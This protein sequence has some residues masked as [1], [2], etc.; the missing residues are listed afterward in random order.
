M[1][2]P[3][4][5]STVRVVTLTAALF[6]ALA[7]GCTPS[8]SPSSDG[9]N[10]SADC[11]SV[12]DC[13]DGAC[14][15]RTTG[16]GS[17][18]VATGSSRA[19]GAS[20]SGNS[21]SGTL[22]SSGGSQGSSVAG[23]SS[24][25]GP[26]SSSAASTS[27]GGSGSSAGGCL[28]CGGRCVDAETDV[29]F[30]GARGD[31]LG[32]NAGESCLGGKTCFG[33]LCVTPC[34]NGLLACRNPGS[35][36]Q[37]CVD[38]ARSSAFCGAG[39]DCLGSNAGQEC[40]DN[41]VCSDGAC[42]CLP[43]YTRV[44]G[45]CV[46]TT[47]L[48]NSMDNVCTLPN[49]RGAQACNATGTAFT[50]DCVATACDTGFNLQSGS[51]VPNVCPPDSLENACLIPNGS[52]VAGCNDIGTALVPPCTATR[53]DPGHHLQ[54]GG[55]V[56]NVCVPNS[57][58]NMCIVLYGQG[59]RTCD[60]TGSGFVGGCTAT[61]CNPGYTLQNGV[62]RF[63][64]CTPGAVTTCAVQGGS[65][66]QTCN[67]EGTGFTTMCTATQ[68]STGYNLQSGRCVA[69]V[70]AP[71]A[72]A[73]CAIA[74]GVGTQTCNATGSAFAG[75]CA[76]T[77][78]NAGFNLQAGACVPN[79]CTPASTNNACPVPNGAGLRACNATGSAY[80]GPCAATQCNPGFNL[81]NGMCVA[82]VCTPGANN[83]PCTT[84][85]GV[86]GFRACNATGS[87]FA[88]ACTATAPPP[89]CSVGF[90][91]PGGI[92]WATSG[93]TTG[94]YVCT[95]GGTMVSGALLPLNQVT[96]AIIPGLRAGDF[97]EASV[98]GAGGMGS[99][100]ADYA[101]PCSP[102]DV[103]STPASC[104]G[105]GMR[106]CGADGSW[107]ACSCGAESIPVVGGCQP[108]AT[109][110][111]AR[112]E[113]AQVSMGATT[114]L[115]WS[116]T[117]PR[118]PG[119]LLQYCEIPTG[120][121]TCSTFVDLPGT[122][123]ANGSLVFSGVSPSLAGLFRYLLRVRSLDGVA[124]SQ[125][126]V[127]LRVNS[128]YN[129]W[130]FVPDDG[131]PREWTVG[132]VMGDSAGCGYA[133]SELS[134]PTP[135]YCIY[136]DSYPGAPGGVVAVSSRTNR[137]VDYITGSRTGT[138]ICFS[139]S[140]P[141]EEQRCS[142]G[143][144]IPRPTCTLNAT[145]SSGT[146]STTFALAWTSS[147]ADTC[148]YV[149]DGLPARPVACNGMESLPGTAAGEGMHNVVLN[150]T[151]SGGTSSCNTSFTVAAAN[152]AP[153]C[154]INTL[155]ASGTT[156]TMFNVQ[157]SSTNATTCTYTLDGSAPQSVPCSGDLTFPGLN[158]GV[159]NHAVVL[160][161][162]GAGGSSS[163][164]SAFTV[165]AVNPAP[166]CTISVSP[167]SGTTQTM[168]SVQWSSTNATTCTYSLD[169]GAAQTQ[170]CSGSLM[171]PGSV[172]GVGNHALVL[173]VTGPGGASSCNTAFTVTAPAAAPTCSLAV[174][175]SSGTL[176]STFDVSWGST[177]ATTCSYSLNGAPAVGV[178][179][180]GAL[181]L[182][183]SAV[184]VG[185]HSLVFNAAGAGGTTSCNASFTVVAPGSCSLSVNPGNGGLNTDFLIT[186][187]SSNATTC[188]YVFDNGAPVG[189]DCMGM[190]SGRGSDFGAGNHTL[191]LSATGAGGTGTCNAAF[192][193][194]N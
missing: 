162:T 110:T 17:S 156:Q 164:S 124:Y 184:G 97:C 89:T 62:C 58:G 163:C 79:L 47:C 137:P 138:L 32:A 35:N 5:T 148:N 6:A 75:L 122:E 36:T 153:T 106:T 103:D 52:G 63:M 169:G 165:T 88:T 37:V 116:V 71:G 147:N 13:V 74:N 27:S 86:S 14:K 9:C 182:P 94:E 127:E 181:A 91:V 123:A 55:C 139:D 185:T 68:C 143:Q 84:G 112:F 93:A 152:P 48:A 119:T 172:V 154:S 109:L 174:A 18:G 113:P 157:W 173:A 189:V 56:P 38:P 83:V 45:Q 57:T 53:C 142:A 176:Q 171:F 43:G 108:R 76:G 132:N 90:P 65:G 22:S 4:S 15:P 34:P 23:A 3:H 33:G 149:F 167:Q 131:S 101:Y 100:R 155:P 26:S 104:G 178:D 188:S 150:V 28:Q 60:V 25:S 49:G 168:F 102:G 92:T 67:P 31:C 114:T 12:Q 59:V 46:F 72:T 41:G 158:V 160:S 39:M 128:A 193:V 129:R 73:E 145:P 7:A 44:A 2:H 146:G 170:P 69:N 20:G 175:P 115:A 117:G 133:C 159:G 54:N 130:C 10:T 105:T 42:T 187:S 29:E 194:A 21:G 30:C 141:I 107:G 50:G 111:S 125:R 40:P 118:Q 151:G 16:G 136:D 11:P 186:W 78:C 98:T 85:A 81:Q 120:A 95:V 24:L 66:T 161:V 190:L 64:S 87:A 70:C 177:Q 121:D 140:V 19:S 82:N 61:A 80:A 192:S 144:T 135:A 134:P 191:V 126:T 166:A 96:P 1:G 51:C 99:C 183:A 8:G 77:R 179:C 180:S